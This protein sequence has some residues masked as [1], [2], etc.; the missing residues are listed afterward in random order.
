[1]DPA[2]A[3]QYNYQLVEEYRPKYRMD[4]AGSIQEGPIYI[5]QN[6]Q[7]IE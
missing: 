6:D 1:M 7:P 5:I 4:I 2:H 3:A